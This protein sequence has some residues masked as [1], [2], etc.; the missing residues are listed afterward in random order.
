MKIILLYGGQ[1]AE[2]DVSKLSAFSVLNAVYYNYYQVQLVYL[3]KTG[4]WLKGP[5]LS[6]EPT[7]ATILDLTPENA[8]VIQPC[9]IQE[10]ESIV[11][12]LLHGPNGE[13]GTIQGAGCECSWDDFDFDRDVSVLDQAAEYDRVNGC[14]KVPK[15]ERL[16]AWSKANNT[17]AELR[18][19]L[20]RSIWQIMRDFVQLLSEDESDALA[21]MDEDISLDGISGEESY[22]FVKSRK[23][24]QLWME[25]LKKEMKRN[26]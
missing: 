13:D 23:K 8:E 5:L 3:T 12:P 17:A 18:H 21:Y 16:A 25:G 14:R 11:F 2:H 10:E 26:V 6:E 1:S 15:E 24:Y 7:S 9:A 19:T 4:Q 22:A 20:G